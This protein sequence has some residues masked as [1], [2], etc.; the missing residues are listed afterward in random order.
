MRASTIASTLQ[1][2]KLVDL[3]WKFGVTA[4]TDELGRVGSTFLQ[5]KFT[6]AKGDTI[7]NVHLELTLSQ[8]Y[9]F[10]GQ[11]EKVKSLMDIMA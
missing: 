8:F 4:S 10:L 5:L 7:E 11:L 9:E 2:H 6:I 3:E 1:V